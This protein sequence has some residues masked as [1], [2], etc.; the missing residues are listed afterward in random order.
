MGFFD[1]L[2]GKKGQVEPHKAQPQSYQQSS[3][4]IKSDETTSQKPTSLKKWTKTVTVHSVYKKS[5]SF[6][7]DRFEEWQGGQC[8]N[9]GILNFEIHLVVNGDCIEF[10]IPQSEKFRTHKHVTFPFLGSQVL[11]DRVQYIDAPGSSTDPTKPIVL[12]IFVKSGKIDYIRLAM[13]FPD[14]IVEFYGYQIESATSC[15]NDFTTVASNN[16]QTEDY[17]L[18]FLSSLVNVAACDGEIADAEMQTIMAYIQREGLNNSDLVRVLTSPSTI[19]HNI[20]QSP[21]LRAQHLRD[22][23]TLSMVDGHFHPREYALC[24]QI[25]VGLGFHPNVIDIIRQ[26]LNNQIGANI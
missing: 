17:K 15:P 5:I 3:T 26:E 20:P 1:S 19:P 11:E 2:F 9:R 7:V 14:R 4:E 24:Q 16:Q 6:H 12:H 13:S 10:D 23:V 25:A 22:V 21:A 8:I 18:T